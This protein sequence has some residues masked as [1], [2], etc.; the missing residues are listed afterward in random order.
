M[1]ATDAASTSSIADTSVIT[2]RT[3]RTTFL[4]VV[5][6]SFALGLALGL[7]ALRWLDSNRKAIISIN[8]VSVRQEDFLHRLEI[9][10]TAN[11][12]AGELVLRQMIAEE[13]TLQ[14]ARKQGVLPSDEEVEKRYAEGAKQT[15]FAQNLMTTH[16]TPEDVKRS[17]QVQMAELALFSKGVTV[18]EQEIREFYRQNVDHKNPNARYYQ[19]ETVQ[20]AVIVTDK[21]AAAKKALEALA[22]GNTFEAVARA[23]SKD[24]SAANGGALPPVRKGS[25]NAQKFP[26][27]EQMLFS[28]KP[29]EQ[30]N[31]VK[32]A[33]AWWIIRCTGHVGEQT[34]QYERV[35]EECRTGALLA[36]GLAS[37][38]RNMQEQFAAFQRDAQIQVARPEYRNVAVLK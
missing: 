16:Q 7:I 38:G 34:T 29:G 5:L 3:R 14:F 21:E 4:P 9:S 1:Q 22:S 36:K 10:G 20:V 8:G 17:L 15:G 32:L 31:L 30:R 12:T 25:L 6:L 23:F 33:G 35:R 2:L 37:N 13:V 26:E 28:M 24:K 19:P 18:S 11:G 27:M